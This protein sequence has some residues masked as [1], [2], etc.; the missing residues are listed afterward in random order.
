MDNNEAFADV[1]IEGE[2]PFEALEKDTPSESQPEK[3]PEVAEPVVVETPEEGVNTPEEQIPF[4]KHPRWI[5]RE[6]ELEELRAFRESVEPKL[7]EFEQFKAR[8]E[9]TNEEIPAWFSELYGDNEKAWKAY[10]EHEKDREE[11]LERRAIE[12]IEQRQQEA[13]AES[14][15]WEKFVENGF[16]SLE[17]KGR[18]FNRN[19]LTNFMLENPITDGNNNLDFEKSLNLFEKLNP[20][21]A[22]PSSQARK[23]LAD[24][25]TKS[26]TVE[27]KRKDYLTPA[28]LRK[29]SWN[30]L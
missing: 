20:Q 22:S 6:Q 7:S 27:P 14:Q 23:Q 29:M 15:K 8:Q 17:S 3:E 18:K 24:T 21:Q 13:Q 25:M 9:P 12:R 19:E 30:Q 16:E 5:E 11:Q 2:N 26:S 1:K 10:A 28:E 4:H